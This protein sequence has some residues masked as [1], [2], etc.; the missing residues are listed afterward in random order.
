VRAL[1]QRVSRAAVHTDGDLLTEIGPGL[2]VLVGV[3]QDDKAAEAAYVASKVA[4]LRIFPDDEGQMNRSVGEVGGSVLVVSQFTLYADTR[5][6]RRPSFVDAAKPEG[7][8]PLV[9]AVV[10]GLQKLGIPTETGVFGAHM[11]VELINNGPVTVLID[12]VS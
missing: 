1:V 3:H 12:T 4:N 8:E 2:L 5:K 10:D 6:G 11:D 7:A 9:E